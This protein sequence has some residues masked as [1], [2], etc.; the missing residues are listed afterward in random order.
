MEHAPRTDGAELM[1]YLRMR[2]HFVLFAGIFVASAGA[3]S[4][5]PD[6]QASKQP[7]RPETQKPVEGTAEEIERYK[8]EL[9]ER[10]KG[11]RRGAKR[12]DVLNPELTS[13]L[14]KRF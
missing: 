4:G 5:A 13:F 12:G 6:G 1:K 14:V 8:T 2:T 10:V 7:L 9:A 11:D 3:F